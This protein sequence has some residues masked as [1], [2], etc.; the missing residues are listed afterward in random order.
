M[1]TQ[2]EILAAVLGRIAGADPQ[3]GV[4]L[5]GSV[6][7]GRERADSDLDLFVVASSHGR[8]ELTQG[9]VVHEEEGYSLV[10]LSIAGVTTHLAWWPSDALRQALAA[11]PYA[12]YPFSR[13]EILF[14][15]RRVARRYQQLSQAY[16]QKHPAISRA[17]EQQ[18]DSLRLHKS[19]RNH[20]L[21]FA[22]WGEFETHLASLARCEAGRP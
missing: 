9:T 6:Q 5:F 7:D 21:T 12:F 18:L 22:T 19:D 10:E 20:A 8:I 15:E 13:G 2:R 11:R 16:F 1:S 17:W 14:D 4:V 3:C